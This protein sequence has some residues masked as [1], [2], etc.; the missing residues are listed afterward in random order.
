MA[1]GKVVF[2]GESDRGIYGFAFDDA[3]S[4]HRKDLHVYFDSRCIKSS[5]AIGVG[6]RVEFQYDIE[7][8]KSEKPRMRFDS[9]EVLEKER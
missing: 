9:M 1:T 7:H 5:T 3:V 6:D 8:C 4:E 2:I